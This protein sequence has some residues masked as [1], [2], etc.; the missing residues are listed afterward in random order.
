MGTYELYHVVT[1][2]PF[3]VGD[4]IVFDE[5]H[6]SGVYNRVMEKRGLINEIYKNGYNG[7]LEHHTMVALRELALEEVRKEKF[8]EYPSRLSCLYTSQTYEEAEKW[9]DLFVDLGR[10]TYNIVKI[11]SNGNIFKGNANKCFRA[12][13]SKEENKKL[14]LQYWEK[15][16]EED[17][18]CEVLVDGEI[19]IIEVVKEINKNIGN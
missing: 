13:T 6:H 16:C 11:R 8:N 14:A 17:G 9:A 1:D 12:T 4:K 18:I 15:Q 2:K 3:K 7:E 5:T 19:E 10:P